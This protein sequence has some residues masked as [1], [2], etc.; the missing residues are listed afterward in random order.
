MNKYL[1]FSLITITAFIAFFYGYYELFNQYL[2][3]PTNSLEASNTTI[4]FILLITG[5]ITIVFL[6]INYQQQ[7]NQIKVQQ[8]ELESNRKDV[9]FNRAIDLIYK[10]LE[11]TKQQL[12]IG[13]SDLMDI[14]STIKENNFCL[15]EHHSLVGITKKF[16]AEQNIYETILKKSRLDPEDRKF[17]IRLIYENLFNETKTFISMFNQDFK[18]ELEREGKYEEI[19]EIF[20]GRRIEAL[21][22][23]PDFANASTKNILKYIDN[24]EIKTLESTYTQHQQ[25]CKSMVNIYELLR[26]NNVPI[27]DSI[28]Q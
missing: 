9:E 7:R 4:Q 15:V 22:K 27:P 21:R 14:R 20:I 24:E 17:L 2:E 5:I 1:K 19:K 6:Y 28:F 16:K 10:Q 11:R 23:T 12:N 18:K 25:D 13:F 3:S 26:K 8:N